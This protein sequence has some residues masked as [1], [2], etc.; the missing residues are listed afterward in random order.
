MWHTRYSCI[1]V[2][3]RESKKFCDLPSFATHVHRNWG[4]KKYIYLI[5]SSASRSSEYH[6]STSTLLWACVWLCLSHVWPHNVLSRKH[7]TLQILPL[8]FP[9]IEC[10]NYQLTSYFRYVWYFG[11]NLRSLAIQMSTYKHSKT[12]KNKWKKFLLIFTSLLIHGLY[13]HTT[14]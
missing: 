3:V 10:G 4:R 1:A 9:Q 7:L 12:K 5:R 11:Y 14:S 13:W 8:S 2:I 6:I